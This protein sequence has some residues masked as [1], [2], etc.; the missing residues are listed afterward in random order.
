LSKTRN[1]LGWGYIE[2]RLD[3]GR[4]K[5]LVQAMRAFLGGVGEERPPPAAADVALTPARIEPPASLPDCVTANHETRLLHAVGRSFRDLAGLRAGKTLPGPD[6]VAAPR[7]RDELKTVLAWAS[8]AGYGVIPF[9][10][11]SSVVGGVNPEDTGDLPA[12]VSIDLQGL[13]RVHEI[14]TTD[15]VVHADAGILGPDLDAAL[16]PHGLA[17][18][19]YPQSYFHSTLGGWVATRGAGHFSTLRAKIEDRVQ[20]LTVL[21]PDGR[22]VATRPLPAASVGPDPNRLWAGSEGALGVITGV[23]LRVVPDPAHRDNLS[24]GFA[25]FESALAASRALLQ[26]EVWPAQMRVLDPF[27]HLV[28]GAMSGRP[29]QGA[30]MILGFEGGRADLVAAHA[31]A[32]GEIVRAHGGEPRTGGGSSRSESAGNWRDTFFM[33]PYLRDV[34]L[35]HAVIGDTFETAVPWSRAV[36]FYHAVRAAALK[37]VK[38]VGGGSLPRTGSGGVTCRVTHAY[39]DGVALYFSFYCPGRHG[40]LVDQWRRIKAA[41]SEAVIAGGGSISHHHAMG[42]DHKPWAVKELPA[43]FRA[44]IRGAKRELDPKGLMNPGLW[45]EN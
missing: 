19:H 31:Q 13:N 20:A 38:E 34:L 36:D 44:A 6:A 40:T 27:E 2:D 8:D 37:A 4:R 32:A 22:E 10:G 25:D 41:A 16:K 43:P 14:E 1:P 26:A 35:D 11:G 12:V 9:G 24:V 21:L 29:G 15:R 23:R 33:Q 17:V 28:S 18:R 7:S 5:A 3:G 39:P 30:L 45:F 42:R